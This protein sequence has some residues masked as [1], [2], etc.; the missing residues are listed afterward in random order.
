MKRSTLKKKI[1]EILI[2]FFDLDKTY[3]SSK[4]NNGEDIKI[5]DELIQNPLDA[6]EILSAI[7]YSCG[8]LVNDEMI[9]KGNMTYGEFIN[10]FYNEIEKEKH[11][12]I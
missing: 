1:D 7:E 6:Y 8:I 2:N 11:G 3:F 9:F 12:L 5:Q 10:V 4:P